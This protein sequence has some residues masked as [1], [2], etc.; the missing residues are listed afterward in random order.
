RW[1]DY[2][3]SFVVVGLLAIPNFWLGMVLIA[4][5]SVNLGLLPSFGAEG[6]LSLVIPTLALA[7]RL[8]A[9][10]AR[11]TRGVVIEE[12]RKDYVRT[13][14][15][16]GMAPPLVLRRHVLRNVMIPTVTVIGLQTGYLLGGSVVVERLCAWPGIGDLMLTAV[17][18]RDYTLIQA[19]YLT[20]QNVSHVLGVLALGLSCTVV[21]GHAHASCNGSATQTLD[22]ASYGYS[23]SICQGT[24]GV[25]DSGKKDGAPGENINFDASKAGTY[26]AGGSHPNTNEGAHHNRVNK[27]RTRGGGGVDEGVAGRG[28][29]VTITNAGDMTLTGPN[30]PGSIGSLISGLSFGGDGDS[31]NDNYK[32]SGGHGGAGNTVT[33][34]NS[35]TLIVESLNGD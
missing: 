33:I 7:A 26:T 30:D 14:R 17:S 16:K 3:I 15:A 23:W 12:L 35:G 27:A 34:T 1:P 11:M 20:N 18:V 19:T 2:A 31:D 25:D 13:A 21:A 29:T 22:A 6:P 10:V 28:G 24:D 8:I 4:F 32:S 5:L 9:L